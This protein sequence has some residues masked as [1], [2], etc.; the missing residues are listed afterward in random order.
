MSATK[1]AVLADLTFELPLPGKGVQRDYRDAGKA[2][3]VEYGKRWIAIHVEAAERG[4]LTAATADEFQ[5]RAV[6]D[7]TGTAA[8]L[9]TRGYAAYRITQFEDGMRS[10]Y[11]NALSC[12]R[13]YPQNK[14]L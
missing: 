10:G 5:R 11:K 14:T 6:A 7:M 2:L 3:G 4:I 12:F 9:R 8:V 1:T 13:E